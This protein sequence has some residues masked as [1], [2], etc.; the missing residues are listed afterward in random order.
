LRSSV[1]FITVR[2][3]VAILFA[4]F[5]FGVALGGGDCHP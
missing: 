5:L 2:S 4:R 3:I 1:S